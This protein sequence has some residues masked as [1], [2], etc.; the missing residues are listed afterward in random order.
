MIDQFS[1]AFESCTSKQHEALSLAARHFS[2][3]EIACRLGIS[4]K[5][6]D[7]R[8]DSVRDRLGGIQRA[9]VLRHYRD[10]LAAQSVCDQA[11]KGKNPPAIDGANGKKEKGESSPLTPDNRI[12]PEGTQQSGGYAFAFEDITLQKRNGLETKMFSR[13]LP[14]ISELGEIGKLMV[15]LLGTATFLAAGLLCLVC[16]HTLSLYLGF[17]VVS[18]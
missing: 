18:A 8:I 4:V 12:E 2:S 15:I 17:P 14:K 1:E 10:W 7:R 9:A 11:E 16:V 13:L 5:A 3:K 6:V